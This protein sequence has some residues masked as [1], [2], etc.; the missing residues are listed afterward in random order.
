MTPFPRQSAAPHEKHYSYR[1][2][3]NLRVMIP[4]MKPFLRP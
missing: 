4:M 3:Y 1:K 2:A